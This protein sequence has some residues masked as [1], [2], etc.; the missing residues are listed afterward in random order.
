MENKLKKIISNRSEMTDIS[1]NI[2]RN[3]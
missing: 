3:P 1:F 2:L